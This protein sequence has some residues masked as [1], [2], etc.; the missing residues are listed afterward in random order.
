MEGEAVSTPVSLQ[1]VYRMELDGSRYLIPL[2]SVYLADSHWP[3]IWEPLLP[4][5]TCGRASQ[6]NCFHF[7]LGDS[8]QQ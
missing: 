4:Q 8:Q 6:N 5:L 3:G 2:R 7:D 1:L